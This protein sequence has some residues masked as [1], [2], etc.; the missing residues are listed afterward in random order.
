VP[1]EFAQHAED[2]HELLGRP[3]PQPRVFVDW[4]FAVGVAGIGQALG[5]DPAHTGR[6]GCLIQ[7]AGAFGAQPVGELEVPGRPAR[8]DLA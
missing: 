3:D 2:G 7:I 6:F 5:D 1:F 8:V 4:A